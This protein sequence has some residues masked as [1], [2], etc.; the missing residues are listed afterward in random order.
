VDGVIAD[1]AVARLLGPTGGA[2]VVVLI[3]PTVT[4]K[5]TDFKELF[6]SQSQLLF[7]TVPQGS[8]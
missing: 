4:E 8:G 5:A 7:Y 2:Q 1:M 6:S 3:T